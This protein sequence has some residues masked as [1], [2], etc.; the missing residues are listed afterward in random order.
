MGHSPKALMLVKQFH[1][2]FIVLWGQFDLLS[3]T[4]NVSAELIAIYQ[5]PSINN[6]SVITFIIIHILY[7][8]YSSDY[9]ELISYNGAELVCI[10]KTSKK[11]RSEKYNYFSQRTSSIWIC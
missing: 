9:F 8:F 7:T 5:Q 2:L 3:T 10:S 1:N 11:R 4:V 6:L